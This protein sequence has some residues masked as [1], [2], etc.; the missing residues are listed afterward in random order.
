MAKA[1]QSESFTGR[2]GLYTRSVGE[3]GPGLG[4]EVT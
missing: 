2:G 1:Q 3:V 4:T